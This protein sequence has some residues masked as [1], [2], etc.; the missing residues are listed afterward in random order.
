MKRVMDADGDIWE[1]DGE[2]GW[3]LA[4]ENGTPV[5]DRT[6]SNLP[7]LELLERVWGPLTEVPEA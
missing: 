4:V 5:P 1:A 6:N 7:S 2:G 3:S